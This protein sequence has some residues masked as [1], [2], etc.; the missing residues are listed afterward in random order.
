[1]S[2]PPP[3][4]PEPSQQHIAARRVAHLMRNADVE[5]ARRQLHL[6]SR[7]RGY[8]VFKVRDGKQFVRTLDEMFSLAVELE[9]GNTLLTWI[10]RCAK[11]HWP[12][13]ADILLM[14]RFMNHQLLLME[15]PAPNGLGRYMVDFEEAQLIVD[16]LGSAVQDYQQGRP[17]SRM[18]PLLAQRFPSSRTRALPQD[19]V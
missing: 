8:L 5:V 17:P 2:N 9:S 11:Q 14:T 18:P 3:T 10:Q 7:N 16:Y 1:M 15:E 13:F 12:A 4:R 6:L 19:A